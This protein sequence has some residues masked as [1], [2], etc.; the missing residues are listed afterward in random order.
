LVDIYTQPGNPTE[1]E[2]D[3]DADWYYQLPTRLTG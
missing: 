2:R 3:D 1:E